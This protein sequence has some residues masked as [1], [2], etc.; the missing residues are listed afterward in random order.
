MYGYSEVTYTDEFVDLICEE[1]YNMKTGAR[2]LQTIMN[3]I[4]QMC[5]PRIMKHEYDQNLPIEL[6]KELILEYK[7]SNVRKY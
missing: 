3:E 2:A 7:K 1:A 4:Q 6:N 5:L